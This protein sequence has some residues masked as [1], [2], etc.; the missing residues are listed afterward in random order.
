MCP[1]YTIMEFRVAM[2]TMKV[3]SGMHVHTSY[4]FTHHS[5]LQHLVSVLFNVS[6]VTSPIIEALIRGTS[7]EQLLPFIWSTSFEAGNL[8]RDMNLLTGTYVVKELH[9][10]LS[11]QSVT[12]YL[13]GMLAIMEYLLLHT[14]HCHSMEPTSLLEIGELIRSE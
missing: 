1:L 4:E 5:S 12:V 13:K 14:H 6:D 7:M 8:L 2:Y 10:L 11:M 3:T 9:K